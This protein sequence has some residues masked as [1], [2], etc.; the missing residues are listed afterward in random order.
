MEEAGPSLTGDSQQPLQSVLMIQD[1]AW[2]L[3]RLGKQLCTLSSIPFL[4]LL[5]QLQHVSMSGGKVLSSAV[6]K[7]H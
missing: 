5:S 2:P 3:A 7:P 4:F 6:C 1:A